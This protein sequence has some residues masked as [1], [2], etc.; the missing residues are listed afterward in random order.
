MKSVFIFEI[1]GRCK[2]IQQVV[3]AENELVRTDDLEVEA[4][5]KVPFW[6]FRFLC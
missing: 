1:G 2:L 3:V 4:L 6:L 5:H